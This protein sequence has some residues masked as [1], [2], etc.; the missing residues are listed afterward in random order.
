MVAKIQN[1]P[2]MTKSKGGDGLNPVIKNTKT[3]KLAVFVFSVVYS[4]K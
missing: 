2:K 1:S 3:A 4:E